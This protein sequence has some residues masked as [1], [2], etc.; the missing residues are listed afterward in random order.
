MTGTHDEVG[1]G[2]SAASAAERWERGTQ[3][4]GHTDRTRRR[5][6]ELA[7]RLV[8]DGHAADVDE[9]YDVLTAADR[10]TS[11][12]MWLVVHMTYA[13]D[14]RLDGRDLEPHEFKRKPEG[15]TGGALNIVPAYVG[16]L[17]ANRLTQ[18]T[19]A[20]TMGQGHCVASIDATNVLVGDMLP[21][22]AER[23]DVSDEGLSRLCRDFYSYAL[24]PDGRPASPLGSHVNQNTAGGTSEGGYLGF[25]ELTYVHTPLPGEQLVV[26]LSDGAF[27][28]QRGSDWAPRWWRASD[29]GLVMPIMIANGRRIDQRTTLAQ[30]G[31]VDWLRDHLQLNG[32]DPF[33]VDGRDPA[34]FAWAILEMERRLEALGPADVPAPLPYAIAETTKGF[35]FPGAGTN[36]AHNLPLG[37][38]PADDADARATFHA[39]ARALWVAPD[40]LAAS[41]ERLGEG[42]GERRAP[43]R[44]HPIA[45]R[46]VALPTLPEPRWRD[47]DCESHSP[48][49][50]LDEH[51]VAILDAN[52]ALRVRVG[53]PD[54]M[55]SNRMTST[56][57]RCRHRVTAPEPG[58][59]EA[60]DGGVITVLNEEAVICAALGNTGG[61]SLA[62]TY[63]AF[64][65]KMLGAMRQ[66][67]IFA[68]HQA[69]AGRPPGWLSVPVVMTSHTWENGKNEQ[70]HQDPTLC[71]ALLGEMTDVAPVLFP[72]DWNSA[73]AALDRV[74]S[75]RGRVATLVVPKSAVPCRLSPAQARALVDDGAVVCVPDEDPEVVVAA[76]GAFQL[77]EALVASRRLT[78][79]GVRH[80]VTALGEPGRFRLPRDD[81][82]AD[83]LADDATL[84]AAFPERAAARV[85]VSHT[86]PQVLTGVVR[87]LDTGPST[88]RV[89]GYV[90]RGGT[91]DTPGMLFANRCTWAHVVD[92]VAETTDRDPG[93]LLD[94]HERRALAGTGDPEALSAARG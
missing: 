68:R 90:N 39:G 53:N 26:F 52:P 59:P 20:W 8:A 45:R 65:V 28:E 17:A 37:A 22:H 76:V 80:V 79:R 30:Q 78:E 48:M 4:L 31:G 3:V 83:A 57:E 47:A 82:E 23:Y 91:F 19:R 60:V 11:A 14:V 56:L 12:A 34:A 38:S 81:R 94:E 44:E 15:H 6:D 58:V 85:F 74:Y 77:G 33:D 18:R 27:E 51:F 1:G 88:T 36:R 55:S 50:G 2:A 43:G 29:S 21:E 5:V 41:I 13:R 24:T 63:E 66:A 61:I 73:V 75:H 35:G 64:G 92:A 67:V 25:T 10:V 89:L 86:R 32:F 49:S 70:S 16:H 71:E 7:R 54:E 40:E 87:R 62:V 42:V 46:D 9:V 69:V 72:V 93:A 84:A